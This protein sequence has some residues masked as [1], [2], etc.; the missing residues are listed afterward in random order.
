MGEAKVPSFNPQVRLTESLPIRH[1]YA[2]ESKG[3][4]WYY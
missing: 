2:T 4:F 3:D 1:L